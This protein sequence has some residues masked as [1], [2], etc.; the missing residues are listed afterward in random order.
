[1]GV[2]LQ[3]RSSRPSEPR[4][5]LTKRSVS[6]QT[7]G[8]S[9]QRVETAFSASRSQVLRRTLIFSAAFVVF[10]FLAA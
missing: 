5:D 2:R 10:A 3:K 1:M 8:P 4:S 7:A 6:G 9:V